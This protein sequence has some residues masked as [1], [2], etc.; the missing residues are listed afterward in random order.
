MEW[1]LTREAVTGVAVLG[2]LASA[3]ASML[4]TRGSIGRERA[5]QLNAAG[6]I[7]MGLSV[8]LFIVVGFRSH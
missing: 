1:I 2:A 5:K 7:L 8:T 4:Q 6:Y 3:A